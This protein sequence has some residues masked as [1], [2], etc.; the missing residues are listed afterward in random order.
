MNL[1]VQHENTM[2]CDKPSVT[3]LV[4][5]TEVPTYEVIQK[6][7]CISTG[8]ETKSDRQSSSH[9]GVQ[10]ILS[11]KLREEIQQLRMNHD[12][13]HHEIDTEVKDEGTKTG[14]GTGA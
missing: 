12:S 9:A 13:K 6:K 5:R 3:K 2:R 1:R 7:H 4:N 14:D 10:E 11:T 8:L